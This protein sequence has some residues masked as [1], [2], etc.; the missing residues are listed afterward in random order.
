MVNQVNIQND[1]ERDILN[2]QDAAALN[3]YPETLS[4]SRSQ[5]KPATR[6]DDLIVSL[7]NAHEN[8]RARQVTEWERMRRQYFPLSV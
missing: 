2:R 5:L 7:A 1:G 8:R 4:S 6:F 3:Y